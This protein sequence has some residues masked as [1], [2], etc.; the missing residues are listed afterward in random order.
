MEIL[1]DISAHS[2]CVSLNC[3]F[4]LSRET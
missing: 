3:V 1:I 2:T 4:I